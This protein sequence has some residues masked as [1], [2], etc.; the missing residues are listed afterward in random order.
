M[1][2]TL[3]IGFS[4]IAGLLVG[5]VTARKGKRWMLWGIWGVCVAICLGLLP[6]VYSNDMDQTLVG[7]VLLFSVALPFSF[8]AVAAGLIGITARALRKEDD[9]E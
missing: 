3:I 2:H 5:Y 4:A 8:C 7:V 9:A 6:L 1:N